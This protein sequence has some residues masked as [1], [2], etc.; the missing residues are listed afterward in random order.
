MF[1]SWNT[2]KV[3]N[4]FVGNVT[5]VESSLVPFENGKFAKTTVVKSFKA[6]TRAVASAMV[7]KEMLRM[8]RSL[9][10]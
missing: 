9:A 4:Y 3:E 1:Y 5:L 7:K 8:N 10:K 6:K 2:K